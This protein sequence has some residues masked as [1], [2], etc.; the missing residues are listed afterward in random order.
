MSR[1]ITKP[2]IAK[3][4][5]LAHELELDRDALYQ[6]VPGGSISHLTSAEGSRLIDSLERLRTGAERVPVT[7]SE[8]S[9]AGSGMTHR[10][11]HFIYFLLGRLG[12]LSDPDHVHNFLRKYFHVGG[13]ESIRTRKQAGAVIEAL[14]AM[15]KR[16]VQGRSAANS[17]AN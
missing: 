17:N 2:Q 14:K 7:R 5:A 1:R 16:K 3:I 13:V 10:Q 11:K 9:H 6:L 12:W 4:W 15:V 8:T